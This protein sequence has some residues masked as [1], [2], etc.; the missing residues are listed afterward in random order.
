M[1][2]LLLAPSGGFPAPA[3]YRSEDFS[4]RKRNKCGHRHEAVQY[5]DQHGRTGI[6]AFSHRLRK[7]R[8]DKERLPGRQQKHI[9]SKE[10]DDRKAYRQ[11]Q[12]RQY[13]VPA[14]RDCVDDGHERED[15]QPPCCRQPEEHRRHKAVDDKTHHQP[16][17][18][19]SFECE[20]AQ[21]SQRHRQASRQRMLVPAVDQEQRHGR[22]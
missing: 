11:S 6:H 14:E 4:A 8:Q 2:V 18:E 3:G 22:Q 9:E 13:D 20:R 12:Q 10:Q 21:Q 1:F 19:Q 17:Q 5:K 7:G 15:Q 16:A